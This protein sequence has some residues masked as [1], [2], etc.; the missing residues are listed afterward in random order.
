M[1][2]IFSVFCGVLAV[3]VVLINM[4][5][6]AVCGYDKVAASKRTGEYRVPERTLLLLSAFFGSFGMLAGMYVFRHK[7]RHRKFTLGVPLMFAVHFAALSLLS[8]FYGR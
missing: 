6:F 4:I 8:W 1:K 7:T 3:A 2:D 5:S